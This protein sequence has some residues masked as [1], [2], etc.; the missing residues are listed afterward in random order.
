MAEGRSNATFLLHPRMT[1]SIEDTMSTNL[2]AWFVG[3]SS[4]LLSS[5]ILHFFL[6]MLGQ[7]RIIS[8]NIVG[9]I[10]GN[11]NVL[12]LIEYKSQR[13]FR[14]L[15]EYGVMCHFF[16]LGLEME[17][18]NLLQRSLPREAILAYSGIGSTY[19]VVTVL[20]NIIGKG[21]DPM[22]KV[23]YLVSLALS[24]SNTSSMVLT[25]LVTDLKIGKSEI[26]R[27]AVKAAVH[28]DLVTLIVMATYL[29]V[30]TNG[31]H[32]A[33][34]A[35]KTKDF[36]LD[37]ARTVTV[38]FM[39]AAE[40]WIVRRVVNPTIE[41]IN[42]KHPEGKPIDGRFLFF[43]F[44]GLLFMS[45]VASV[46]GSN[47]KMNAFLIGLAMI[48]DGKLSRQLVKA[49]NIGLGEFF[50]PFY[51]AFVGVNMDFSH[52]K[53]N[54]SFFDLVFLVSLGMTGKVLGTLV[55][56][57]Y[58]GF[59]VPDAICLGLML[60]VKGHYHV[61]AATNGIEVG[62]LDK[63]GYILNVLCVLTTVLYIPL[64]AV[65]IVKLQRRKYSKQML[66]LQ[67]ISP[68]SR[69]R[70]MVCVQ[71]PEQVPGMIR[72]IE[73]TKGAPTSEGLVVHA[74]DLVELTERA[75]AT[76]TYGSGPEAV[77]VSDEAIVVM[78]EQI[79]AAYQTYLAGNGNGNRIS[80]RRHLA[81]SNYSNM[82]LDVCNAAQDAASTFIVMPFHKKQRADGSMDDGNPELRAVNKKV[83]RHAPCSVGILVDR[84]LR[85]TGNFSAAISED[86]NVGVVF[87]GG[88][89]DR[90]ALCYAGRIAGCPKVVL[91]VVRLIVTRVFDAD[92]DAGQSGVASRYLKVAE[93]GFRKNSSR[94]YLLNPSAAT[95]D[96]E[97]RLDNECFSMFYDRHIANGRVGYVEKYI[98][99]GP[100]A[101]MTLRDLREEIG[102][103]LYIVGLSGRASPVLKAEL[104]EWEDCPELG[105]LGDGLAASDF[106]FG[107]SVLVI[108]QH[109]PERQAEE[110]LVQDD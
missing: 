12:S 23:K 84:G 11:T 25:R 61:L 35:R 17:P 79:T 63:S 80:L 10:I 88:A 96:E 68:E 14:I 109:N 70:M 46:L 62:V 54:K 73:A 104:R 67:L 87:I 34:H 102:L 76:L 60:D 110:D 89:D 33:D 85:G 77:E 27:T 108:Q 50:F 57:L 107:T 66:T 103:N 56:A 47:S 82:H 92:D 41:W 16:V 45:S 106:H 75:A 7:P 83:L 4:L 22:D 36:R 72:L 97:N 21:V 28:C 74:L 38:F 6:R 43:F 99:S 90:E 81:I 91:T 51:Y 37:V 55:A 24:L 48:R 2:Y 44:L 5:R 3:L 49:I 59:G 29:S 1:C 95:P 105:P 65:L 53:G 101:V 9:I 94:N 64:V 26:G 93:Y 20:S 30:Q 100:Q 71:G 18:R 40:L 86:L 58:L 42:R 15:F 69:L 8:E 98:G 31:S 78:R 39:V 19:L 52:W 32:S 13:M